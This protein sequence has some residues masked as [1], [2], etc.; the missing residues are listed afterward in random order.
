MKEITN[1]KK[2]G[3]GS[4]VELIELDL[5]EEML[6]KAKKEMSH[7]EMTII[8]DRKRKTTTFQIG[9]S[10]PMQQSSDNNTSSAAQNEGT[11]N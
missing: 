4:D 7:M 9:L 3:G 8:E 1:N 10:L 6:E 11:Q 2:N 5:T